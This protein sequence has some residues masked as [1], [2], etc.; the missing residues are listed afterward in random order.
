M[1]IAL[2]ASLTTY[3]KT[4]KIKK[5]LEKKGFSVLFPWA[6]DEIRQGKL[7]PEHLPEFKLNNQSKAIKIHYDKIKKSDAILVINE[8]KNKIT[9]YVGGNTLME[10]GFAYILNK[11]IYLLNPIP[12]MIY[13]EEIK[14]MKPIILNGD[15]S[16]ITR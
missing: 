5:D 6:M 4:L 16:L 13:T 15:L 2:C 10:M 9:H 11:K 1:T 8:T 14:A 12:K 7:L 3:K